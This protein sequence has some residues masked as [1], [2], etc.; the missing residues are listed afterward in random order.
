M[1]NA[2]LSLNLN[3]IIK[4]IY[5]FFHAKKLKKFALLSMIFHFSDTFF[6]YFQENL[7]EKMFRTELNNAFC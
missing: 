7:K 4:N 3:K 2:R 6:L 5:I 1:H